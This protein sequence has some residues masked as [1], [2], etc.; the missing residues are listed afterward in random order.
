MTTRGKTWLKR[1]AITL[2]T[3]AVLFVGL[4]GLAHTTF[5]RPILMWLSGAGVTGNC[6][7]GFDQANPLATEYFRKQQLEQREGAGV[8][9]TFRALDFVLGETTK[10]DVQRWVRERQATCDEAR[11]GSALTCS[12]YAESIG[13][14]P[15]ASDLFMLFDGEDR[16][17]ALDLMRTPT[18]A[19]AAAATLTR[20][21]EAVSTNVG[22][23]TKQHGEAA[24]AWLMAEP[25]RM[26]LR[27]FRYQ[28]FVASISAT[29]LGSRGVRVREQ[30]QWATD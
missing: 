1:G 19:A 30:Y 9:K 20:Q 3:L 29:N 15:H 14:A 4:I 21:I 6:P 26:T 24:A 2:A 13:A 16:L 11:Q 27:E 7:L 28:D 22:P 8:A 23:A 12:A 10:A 25:M 17:V 18:D 5:G